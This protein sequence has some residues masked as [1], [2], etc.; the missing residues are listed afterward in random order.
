MLIF[1]SLLCAVVAGSRLA[2]SKIE[3][4]T[5]TTTMPLDRVVYVAMQGLGKVTVEARAGHLSGKLTCESEIANT[6]CLLWTPEHNAFK[7]SASES[8]THL[9]R[10]SVAGLSA[11]GGSLTYKVMSGSHLTMDRPSAHVQLNGIKE[12]KASVTLD[13]NSNLGTILRLSTLNPEVA[14]YSNRLTMHLLGSDQR[15]GTD[16]SGRRAEILLK[17]PIGNALELKLSS[18]AGNKVH[19]QALHPQHPSVAAHAS[20][21]STVRNHPDMGKFSSIKVLEEVNV[22]NVPVAHNQEIASAHLSHHHWLLDGET[23]FKILEE[24]VNYKKLLGRGHFGE[25]FEALDKRLNIA[26]AVKVIKKTAELNSDKGKALINSEVKILD[27]LPVHENVC[28][29]Y[30]AFETQQEV[31]FDY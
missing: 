9:A 12:V 15:L 23:E 11:R 7:I 13:Q 25:V 22:K 27:R 24:E 20:A 3:G 26:V 1:I 29:F 21:L 18:D 16:A 2:D 17:T 19:L 10:L 30:R 6:Y 8:G 28:R 4:N 5:M 31:D 14:Q